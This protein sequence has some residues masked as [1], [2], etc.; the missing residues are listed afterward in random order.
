MDLDNE[1]VVLTITAINSVCGDVMDDMTL[2]ISPL[3]VSENLAGFSISIFPNPSSGS[4][5]LELNGKSDELVQIRIYNAIGNIVFESKNISIN[6]SHTE[7]IN[8]DVDQGVYY[9]RVEGK[10]ILV[11]RKI[12]INR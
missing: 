5:N 10:D 3:G 11:N 8:L 6:K 4:F 1:E 2:A 7:K 12:V 9:L